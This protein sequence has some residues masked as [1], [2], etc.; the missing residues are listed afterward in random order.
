MIIGWVRVIVGGLGSARVSVR[1]KV[2]RETTMRE[3]RGCCALYITLPY[4]KCLYVNMLYRRYVSF[5]FVCF[6]C[7]IVVYN[8]TKNKD[9]NFEAIRLCFYLRNIIK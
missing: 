1:V 3:G 8:K 9:R 2:M 7:S 5:C 6:L 4:L